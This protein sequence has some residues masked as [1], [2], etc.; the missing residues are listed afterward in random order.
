METAWADHTAFSR[1]VTDTH[2]HSTVALSDS[3]VSGSHLESE[4][5]SESIGGH[6]S[7]L[8]HGSQAAWLQAR[9][10]RSPPF[11]E[12]LERPRDWKNASV[13]NTGELAS[14]PRL[15]L[16]PAAEDFPVLLKFYFLKCIFNYLWDG[17]MCVEARGQH[18]WKLA[19][20]F[21]SVCT[22]E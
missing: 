9:A 19:L 17:G 6:L 20:S 11:S 22:R 2:M 3:Q 10:V 8:L 1:S 12:V 18:F 15:K 13:V 16:P 4:C 7:C 21:Y 14:L 5:T